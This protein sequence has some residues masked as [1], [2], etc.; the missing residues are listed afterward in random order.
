MHNVSKGYLFVVLVSA[1]IG[2]SA[3][4]VKHEANGAGAGAA[5]DGHSSL[6]TNCYA[7][8]AGGTTDPRL[9][10]PTPIRPGRSQHWQ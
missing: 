3:Q 1:S 8:H 5:G 10:Q 7:C 2:L 9:S 4:L 6:K